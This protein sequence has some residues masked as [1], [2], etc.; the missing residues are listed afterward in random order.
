MRLQTFVVLKNLILGDM[1]RVQGTIAEMVRCMVDPEQELRDMT[2]VFFKSL[3][4]KANILYN[5]IP[6]IFS[7]LCDETVLSEENLRFVM[8]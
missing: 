6:D 4:Q 5:M 8:K 3:A 1:I 7:H 2:T